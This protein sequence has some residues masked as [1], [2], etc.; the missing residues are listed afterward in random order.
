MKRRAPEFV[1]TQIHKVEPLGGGLVRLYFAVPK[2]VEWDD[3]CTIIMSSTA[4]PDALGFAVTSV[5]EI[6]IEGGLAVI[7]HRGMSRHVA[8][9]MYCELTARAGLNVTALRFVSEMAP[10]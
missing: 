7:P 5:R 8:S 9:E 2:G 3:Q 10:I 4:V 1:S 6:A